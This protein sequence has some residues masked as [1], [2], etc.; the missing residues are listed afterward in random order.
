[1]IQL[2]LND[3]GKHVEKRVV[4]RRLALD[5][6]LQSGVRKGLYHLHQLFVRLSQ[7]RHCLTPGRF[8]GVRYWRE[9]LPGG[10]ADH[11]PLG[12]APHGIVPGGDVKDQFP[13]GVRTLN[14]PGSGGC[15]F[16]ASQNLQNRIAMPGVTLESPADLISKTGA[17][18][19]GNLQAA[20]SS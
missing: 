15:R 3:S 1:M 13:D 11:R 7:V 8:A 16:Y 5:L 12:S 9:V 20:L 17:F 19:H 10:K 2:V 4:L 6:L 18:G 14:G